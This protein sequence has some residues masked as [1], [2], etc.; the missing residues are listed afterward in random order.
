MVGFDGWLVLLIFLW[1]TVMAGNFGWLWLK[2]YECWLWWSIFTKTIQNVN[3][4]KSNQLSQQTVIVTRPNIQLTHTQTSIR[5]K[6]EHQKGPEVPPLTTPPLYWI[7][8]FTFSTELNVCPQDAFQ[9]AVVTSYIQIHKCSNAWHCTL[10]CLRTDLN[11][12]HLRS[13]VD[14]PYCYPAWALSWPPR[15]DLRQYKQSQLSWTRFSLWPS[16]ARLSLQVLLSSLGLPILKILMLIQ[17]HLCLL[18]QVQWT[19]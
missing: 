6:P 5:W 14:V 12:G 1:L 15:L 3:H 2:I 4:W 7:S 13:P 18:K 9:Y 8:L 19:T 16:Y 17:W 11:C 10:Y